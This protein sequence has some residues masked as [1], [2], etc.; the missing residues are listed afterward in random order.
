[1]FRQKCPE[2]SRRSQSPPKERQNYREL[3]YWRCGN[4]RHIKNGYPMNPI[5]KTPDAQ[6]ETTNARGTNGSRREETADTRKTARSRLEGANE[7]R[8]TKANRREEIIDPQ[9]T[10]GSRRERGTPASPLMP[11]HPMFNI[12]IETDENSLFFKG[13]ICDKTRL[14]TNAW[15]DITAGCPIDT[16]SHDK[17]CGRHKKRPP[18]NILKEAFVKLLWGAPANNLT[19]SCQ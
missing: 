1:M 17:P 2:H 4:T 11:H 6:Y 19:V 14:M 13:W 15:P 10:R 8:K 7:A 18:P 9:K 16:L 5:K 3:T 12:I